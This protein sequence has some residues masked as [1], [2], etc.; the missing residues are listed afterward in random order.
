MPIYEYECLKCGNQLEVMQKMSDA[1]LKQCPKCKAKKLEKII[2]QSAFAF[3]GSGWYV[4]DYS[5]SGGKKDKT[6]TDKT[7]KSEDK[8]DKS[9][10]KTDKTESKTDK[11]ESKADKSESKTETKK[12]TAS[13]GSA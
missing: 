5:K 2:S 1:P 12:E 10:S 3:K 7:D 9:E 13:T 11:S 8:T 4:T 6:D